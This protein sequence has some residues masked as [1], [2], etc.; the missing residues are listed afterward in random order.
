M[1]TFDYNNTDVYY[2][3]YGNGD[4]IVLLH[5]FAEDSRI[6]NHQVNYLKAYYKVIVPDLPGSGQS[7]LLKKDNVTIEEYAH[8]IFNLLQQE[9]I[10]SC[11]MFGHSMGGYITLAFAEKYP[12]FLS[13]YGLIHSNAS[14]DNEE[15]IKTRKQGI[16]LINEYGAYPFIKNTVPN[17]FSNVFK[18]SNSNV[19]EELIERG[20]QFSKEALIQYYAAMINRPDRCNVLKEASVPVLFI[21]GTDDV[22][23]PLDIVINQVHLPFYSHIHIMN[24]VGHMSML[25]SPEQLN[26]FLLSFIDNNQP[27]LY[28]AA[29]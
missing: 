24:N 10:R 2:N 20:R 17:L 25:E 5:G 13:A 1:K 9:G 14:A 8:C 29:K 22:A 21:I 15:K 26:K 19:I 28:K 6:F 3:I 16:K 23:A 11:K 7:G 27:S 12:P 4:A 18:K